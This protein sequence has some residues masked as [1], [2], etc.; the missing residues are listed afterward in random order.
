[1]DMFKVVLALFCVFGTSTS[2]AASDYF[3]E[4]EEADVCKDG[5]ALQPSHWPKEASAATPPVSKLD[6]PKGATSS[7]GG[8]GGGGGGPADPSQTKEGEIAEDLQK[9]LGSNDA[10]CG[11]DPK[12]GR[13]IPCLKLFFAGIKGFDGITPKFRN[14]VLSYLAPNDLRVLY[15]YALS[16]GLREAIVNIATLKGWDAYVWPTLNCKELNP[17]TSLTRR[18]QIHDPLREYFSWKAME[19]VAHLTL[20]SDN[21][22]LLNELAVHYHTFKSLQ[23]VFLKMYSDRPDIPPLLGNLWKGVLGISTDGERLKTLPYLRNLTYLFVSSG[24]DFEAVKS[25]TRQT[26]LT[27]LNVKYNNIGDERA[28]ALAASLS[29]L[30]HLDVSH[31]NIGDEGAKALTVLTGLTTLNVKYNNIG[32]AGKKALRAMTHITKLYL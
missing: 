2:F 13:P 25:L 19:C 15:R 22:Y 18:V 6:T 29:S 24:L 8:G 5:T 31:N 32:D 4:N 3:K 28:K 14:V 17:E 9:H 26:S 16:K 27:T 21:L 10:F 7:G 1:M 20:E 11:T 23:S 12:T 30:R